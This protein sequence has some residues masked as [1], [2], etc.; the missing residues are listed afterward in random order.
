[1]GQSARGVEFAARCGGG[2]EGPDAALE[3]G[4]ARW[5]LPVVAAHSIIVSFD[6]RLGASRRTR[7]PSGD[8]GARRSAGGIRSDYSDGESDH[9]PGAARPRGRLRT[10]R[11]G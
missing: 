3:L 4:T 2:P 11:T 8:A 5:P 6:L 9:E 10:F 1:M 7:R